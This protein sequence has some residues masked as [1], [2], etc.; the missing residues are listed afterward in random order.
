MSRPFNYTTNIIGVVRGL[1]RDGGLLE[2][3]R[4]ITEVIRDGEA[5]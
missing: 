2:R 3:G 1:I 5:Y 4:L